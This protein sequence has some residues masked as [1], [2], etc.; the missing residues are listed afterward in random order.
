[1]KPF[2][3]SVVIPAYNEQATVSA[4]FDEVKH[5]LDGLNVDY[6]I[7]LCD[8]ASQDSTKTAIEKIVA[9]HPAARG[10]YHA[11]NKGL[12]ATFEELYHSAT[13][14]FVLL[15]PGDG[16][17]AAD[18]L[19]QAIT[20]TANC[21]V[22]IIGRRQKQYPLWRKAN[23]WLF[24]H[25]VQWCTGVDLYDIGSVKIVRREIFERV[26]VA[27]HSAFTE[28]ERLLKA[29]K[30]GY[31]ITVFWHGHKARGAGKAS[32]ASLTKSLK[33]FG[34]LLNFCKTYKR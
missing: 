17:W 12:F 21:D 32:G 9:A 8:D 1:M 27:T 18:F 33:A 26:Q 4:V 5:I 31:R 29:R 19:P 13:K 23:S 30:L 20:Q 7:I 10:I 3:L 24:N 34:D 2:S 14:E 25:L 16:Q 28:A 15:L 6:E 11:A 22:V